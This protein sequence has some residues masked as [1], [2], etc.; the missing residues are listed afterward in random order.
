MPVIWYDIERIYCFDWGAFTDGDW[1]SLSA[2]YALLPEPRA[3]NPKG[4]PR[5][6]SEVDDVQGGYLTASVES[7]GLQVF[8][9]LHLTDWRRWDREFQDRIGQLP[10][11]SIDEG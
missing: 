3:E 8:G 9:T 7:P 11:R 4:C 2:I 10:F 1:K 6:Y 5:W